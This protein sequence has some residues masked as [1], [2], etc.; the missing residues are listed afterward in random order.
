VGS[1]VWVFAASAEE[2]APETGVITVDGRVFACEMP[3]A[4]ETDI[5]TL[6]EALLAPGVDPF[7]ETLPGSDRSLYDGVA[8]CL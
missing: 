6:L 8:E 3:V 4:P 2:V 1:C 5:H 7:R